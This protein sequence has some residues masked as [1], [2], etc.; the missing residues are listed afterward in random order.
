MQYKIVEESDTDKLTKTVQD[1]LDQ[2]WEL[3]GGPFCFQH[4]DSTVFAQALTRYDER[5]AGENLPSY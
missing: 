2:E 3:E 1:L 5:E 4:D